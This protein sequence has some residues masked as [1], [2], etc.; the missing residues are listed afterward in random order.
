MPVTSL[1]AI[2]LLV[3]WV[4]A[5]IAFLVNRRAGGGTGGGRFAPARPALVVLWLG[6]AAWLAGWLLAAAFAI[7]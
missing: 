4:V 5:G 3:L 7:L 6:L 2:P 1:I